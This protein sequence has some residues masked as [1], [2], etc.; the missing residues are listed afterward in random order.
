MN[1]Q[2]TTPRLETEKSNGT[3]QGFRTTSTTSTP[4]TGAAETNFSDQA[5]RIGEALEQMKKATSSI[6]EAVAS[7]GTAS[8]DIAKLKLAQSKV[9]ALEFESRAEDKLAEKPLL[10][11]GAAFALGWFLSRLSK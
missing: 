4:T 3:L 9:K 8:G 5:A 2:P 10:Y 11:V 1:N 7:L 6:Y